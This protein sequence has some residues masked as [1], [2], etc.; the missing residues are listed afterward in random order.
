MALGCAALLA[1]AA[2]P[3]SW[4]ERDDVRALADCDAKRSTGPAGRV[5]NAGVSGCD[6]VAEVL[7]NKDADAAGGPVGPQGEPGPES[8]NGAPGPEGDKGISGPIGPSGAHKG[9]RGESGAPGAMGENGH[10]RAPPVLLSAKPTG[11]GA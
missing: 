4:T 1:I 6:D 2:A 3:T 5:A 7:R 10:A 8:D 9:P 11:P